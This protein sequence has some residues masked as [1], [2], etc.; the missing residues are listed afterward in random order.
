MSDRAGAAGACT[1]TAAAW[2]RWCRT[3]STTPPSSWA[4]RSSRS[5]RSGARR[6]GPLPV[7][8]VRDN[9]VGIAPRHQ[10]RVFRLFDKLDA[11]ERGHGRRARA[12]EAHRRAA[13]RARLGRIARR[14]RWRQL[15]LH[16]ACQG[17]T[18]LEST[19][20]AG[21]QRAMRPSVPTL[22]CAAARALVVLAVLGP[23]A[24]AGERP[25]ATPD[26]ERDV[27]PILAAN[28]VSC[29]GPRQQE[30]LL[31]L[32]TRGQAL[33]G[34]MSGS[35]IVP[36]KQPGEPARPA[37]R[38]PGVRPACP[39]RSR[40]SPADRDRAHR[41][42]DRRRA[43]GRGRR[44]GRG[45]RA[46]QAAL[47]L[48]EA[49]PAGAAR[50]ARR[51]LGA[52]PDRRLRAR[53]AREGGPRALARGLARDA[54]P[55]AEPRPHRPAADA[56]GDRRVPRRH[57]APDAYET[58]VDRLLASPHY[59]ERW[60]RPW[61]DLARYAD[62]NG[63]EKDQRRT[64]WKYRDWVIDALN[65]D[66]PFDQFTIEQIAG[67]MLPDATR[68]A[69]DRH[70]LPPQHACSTRRAASTSRSPA[71]RR[72]STASTRPAPS[73]SAR[74]LACAQCHNHKY[75]PFSQKD[76]YRLLAFFDNGEYA[77]HGQGEEVG[78]TLDRRAGA[79]ARDARAGAPARGAAARGRGARARAREPRRS[80][81]SSRRS[82][83]R[84]PGRAPRVRRRSRRCARGAERR[85]RCRD[86]RRRLAARL[87]R[88]RGQGHLHRHGPR[89]RSPGITAFR[90]EALPD[91][92]LPQQGPGRAS[93]GA[94]VVTA[95]SVTR[96][97]AA[98]L[99][100][101]RAAR[102]TS[103]R[104]A[105]RR[106]SSSTP[107]PRRAGAS[108]ADD[109]AGP[110]RTSSS[111][112]SRARSAPPSDATVARSRSRSSS[113]RRPRASEPRPLP[114]LR[115]RRASRP[116]ARA[117][118]AGRGAARPRR[119]RPPSARRSRRQALVAW[120]RPLA[121]SLDAARDRAR[122]R[123]R[124]SSTTMKVATA[125]VHAGARRL[126]A[127]VHAAARTA[128]ASRAPASASTRRAGRARRAR[129][130]PAAEPPRPRALARRATTTRSPRAS[131]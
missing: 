110:A 62:T 50:G 1:A 111:S 99:R 84:S 131:P 19:G 56:R 80:T 40:R 29:H 37:P 34:G 126:R 25:H 102:P 30:S 59:G 54:P 27:R 69:A 71:S 35:V 32:D 86:A 6:G 82:S 74:T 24:A 70:R 42:L 100:L 95:L 16:A 61:L 116:F 92:S 5:S 63:Y 46:G 2:C 81:P 78:D 109:E 9:G 8:F 22:P 121:P 118:A 65:R 125:L 94:F 76:Y 66:M 49:A 83:G 17:R 93:S 20:S 75:D 106:R 128:A 117:A 119:R 14:G 98:P 123:S 31:R 4:S 26:F 122:A 36:G 3:W 48:R 127:A 68:R 51:G 107:T 96:R 89:A 77:V 44:A 18:A 60:A 101:A 113:R 11:G 114:A 10:E 112:R 90:L 47:G 79:R 64:A 130:R 57:R 52:Q 53:A 72:S 45:P 129:R 13:W 103:T 124:P 55:P 28:C 12:R 104:S 7:F 41:G 88:A 87:G 33:K 58:L 97:R 91:P 108:T 43:R 23:H 105:G 15:L 21:V 120:F 85:R 67:D 115:P 73:G 38:R 39:T